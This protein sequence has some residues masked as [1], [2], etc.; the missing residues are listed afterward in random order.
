MAKVEA[1]SVPNP[2][3]FPN[4]SEVVRIEY[5]LGALKVCVRGLRNEESVIVEFADVLGFRVLDERDLL[6]YWPVCSTPNGWLFEIA[7]GGWLSQEVARAG[8]LIDAMNPDA[9]E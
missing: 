6:E 8:S 2:H 3:A 5:A 4:G 1:Q 7:S 9:K